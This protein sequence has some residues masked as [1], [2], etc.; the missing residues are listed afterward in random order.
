MPLRI[1]TVDVSDSDGALWRT[2]RRV[3]WSGPLSVR[4]RLQRSLPGGEEL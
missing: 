1:V 2:P 3:E 4:K